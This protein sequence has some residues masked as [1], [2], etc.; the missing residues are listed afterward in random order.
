M[1]DRHG[2]YVFARASAA[3]FA[4]G[5]VAQAA[6]PSLAVPA[7]AGCAAGV[8]AFELSRVL[9]TFRRRFDF[10][11]ADVAQTEATLALQSLLAP[12][13]P[14]PAMRG[15]AIAPDFGLA[16]A[17]LIDDERPR[18]VVETGSG[19]STLIIAYR[20]QRL[21]RGTVVALEQDE[22]HAA[23]TRAELERHDLTQLARVVH[24]PLVPVTVGG[25]QH[26]WHA[27]HALDDLESIDLVLDD[28]PPRELGSWLRYA[29]LPMFVPKLAP[30]ALFV[31]NM[32][33]PEEHAILARWRRELPEFHHELFATKK[34]HAILRR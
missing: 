16:L 18:L 25:T 20:L 14:L 15:Y 29:S 7:A 26:R 33:G 11:D 10:L 30:G 3:T 24:A 28:G 19:V 21:G 2:L 4:A 1:I 34:G 27:P 31:M 13:R 17:Q 6:W 8:V 23:R 12:R 5:A 32:I 22:G 9:S